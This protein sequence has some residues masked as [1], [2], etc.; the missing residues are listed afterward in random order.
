[1]PWCRRRP[2]VFRG[3]ALGMGVFAAVEGRG[4]HGLATWVIGRRAVTNGFVASVYYWMDCT[5]RACVRARCLVR[6][7][8]SRQVSGHNSCRDL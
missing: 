1:M 2:Y 7:G 5:Y 4:L 6:A 3:D 8:L